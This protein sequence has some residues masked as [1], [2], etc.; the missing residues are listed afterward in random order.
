MQ[1]NLFMPV[2]DEINLSATGLLLNVSILT[3]A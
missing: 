1:F 2:F 3:L